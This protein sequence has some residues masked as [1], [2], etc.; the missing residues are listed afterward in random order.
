MARARRA[1]KTA[2]RPP[3]QEASSEGASSRPGRSHLRDVLPHTEEASSPLELAL[4]RAAE[5]H[6]ETLPRAEIAA[7]RPEVEASLRVTTNEART[8]EAST[9]AEPSQSRRRSSLV[10]TQAFAAL[11]LGVHLA[12]VL[13]VPRANLSS[14]TP[15]LTLREVP[16]RLVEGTGPA[17]TGGTVPDTA[18][19]ELTPGGAHALD[20][21]V[22]A[23]DPGV[24]GDGRGAIE[25]VLLVPHE[26][27]ITLTDAPWNAVGPS[28]TSRIDVADDRATFEDRRAT[29]N[30][31]DTPFL[32]SGDGPHPERRPLASL[33]AREGARVAPSPSTAG[34]RT[35]ES[36][37]ATL[38]AGARPVPSGS[39]EMREGAEARTEAGAP[40]DSPG[41]G[42]I[43]GTGPRAS[44]AARVAT[45]RPAIDPGTASTTSETRD[46]TRDDTDA[47]LLAARL[48]ESFVESSRRAGTREGEGV[49]GHD[50]PGAPGSGGGREAG[51]HARALGTGDG[52]FEA[53][54]TS[55]ARYRRWLLDERR[56]LE[57]AMVFPRA[58]ALAMDQGTS[59]FRVTL[60]R[61]GS[62]VG[63]PRLI[64]SS[65]FT[66]L[67]D[68]ARMAI[69]TGSFAPLPSEIAPGSASVTISLPLE[70]SN[71]MVR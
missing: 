67:D 29:P 58:R 59:V 15:S 10:A 48:L 16:V 68:A 45:G 46:R 63:S 49:G 20:Q 33:D 69:E 54:D 40:S 50:T 1:Q 47:E 56:R 8:D 52:G 9:E 60:R 27:P 6:A 11:S 28:Q 43:G 21:N 17:T 51:G 14:P 71:P 12:L 7:A 18:A 24:G 19:S 36:E 62:M 65:G 31:S 44:E 70:W 57:D 42:I 23:P 26:D 41:V 38:G 32:A 37:S 61:D 39:S 55:D 25:V 35:S 34:I 64:R 5:A 3:S 22:D 13:L 30:P 2:R 66:D 4:L 53:L